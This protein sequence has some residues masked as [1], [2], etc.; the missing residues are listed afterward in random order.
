M[1]ATRAVVPIRAGQQIAEPA[2]PKP[3]KAVTTGLT[4]L[5]IAFRPGRQQSDEDRVRWLQICAKVLARFHPLLVVEAC[6][7]L[8]TN[9]D[10]NPFIPTPQ[11]IHAV[12]RKREADWRKA[13]LEK[14]GLERWT[15]HKRACTVPTD[16]EVDFIRDHIEASEA[17]SVRD[18]AGYRDVPIIAMPAEQFD[19]IPAEA[20]PPGVRDTIIA[21]RAEYR[22][23]LEEREARIR[24]DEDRRL[25]KYGRWLD[26]PPATE[27]AE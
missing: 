11:E 1:T 15:Y 20:F 27:A 16:V 23:Y 5:T 18:V 19:A 25:A 2:R 4:D 17:R 3:P 22:A 8:L 14:Y 12:C 9:N 6:E 13:V 26:G 21:K 24:D 10:A 7:W